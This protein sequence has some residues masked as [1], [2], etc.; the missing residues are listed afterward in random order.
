[1]PFK[2]KYNKSSFPFKGEP[3]GFT[4]KGYKVVRED[5]DE[6]I[7]GEAENGNTIKLDT[8]IKPGSKKE[9]EVIAHEAHHQDEMKSGKLAYD[10]KSVTDKIAGKKYARKDGKLIDQDS[11]I[12]YS[13]GDP[14]L[15]HESRAF[16]ISNKIKNSK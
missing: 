3:D 7:L 5:L 4:Y 12:A 15:P 11:G 9:K 1:M 14:N 10:D 6:G 13:E 8:S 16:K 2:L